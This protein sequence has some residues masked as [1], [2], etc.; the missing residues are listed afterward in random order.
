MEHE[1]IIDQYNVLDVDVLIKEH[2]FPDSNEIAYFAFFRLAGQHHMVKWENVA[3]LKK[4]VSLMIHD[5]KYKDGNFMKCNYKEILHHY[6]I[7]GLDVIIKETQYPDTT[8]FN[9][10]LE[11]G[12]ELHMLRY[13]TMESM[14][15]AVK[16]I[17]I[18]Y[19]NQR[20]S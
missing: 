2:Q 7:L 16:I 17:I 3:G 15:G 5:I 11:L 20:S 8:Y 18:N 12:D 14:R 6:I 19:I 13:D 10:S 9:T 4:K 1:V